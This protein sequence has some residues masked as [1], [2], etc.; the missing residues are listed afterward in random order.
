MGTTADDRF[1]HLPEI[2]SDDAPPARLLLVRREGDD[3]FVSGQVAVRD[4]ELLAR[5]L[6][7]RDIDV[8]E[9]AN[10]AWQCAR[11]VMQ[12]LQ[13][14]LGSLNLVEAVRLGVYVASA[15]G[16][17]E[18]HLVAHGATR[19]ILATLGSNRGQH[20]RTAIGVAA[21]P[22]G[23]PVEVDGTFRLLPG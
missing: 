9:A 17:V 5:G 4:G 11:N 12:A 6:V 2:L 23:S 13:D 19:A 8:D 20:V 3:V 21:L 22:T 18:Q 10:C 14:E 1:A 16:F 7:G 15:P